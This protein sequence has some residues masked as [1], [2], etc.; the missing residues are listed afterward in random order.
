MHCIAAARETALNTFQESSALLMLPPTAIHPLEGT[1]AETQ[2]FV[3]RLDSKELFPHG[4]L[5]A[6]GLLNLLL[7]SRLG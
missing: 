6:T 3:F 4:S 1:G 5:P 2:A 7:S